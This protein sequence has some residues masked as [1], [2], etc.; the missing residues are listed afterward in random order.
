MRERLRA[1]ARRPRDAAWLDGTGRDHGRGRGGG[2]RGATRA[3]ERLNAELAAR[4]AAGAFPCAHLALEDELP[5]GDAVDAAKLRTAF[6]AS[7]ARDAESGR[8]AVGPHLADLLVRHTVKRA[9]ARDCSTGEQ[10]ALLDLHRAGQCLAAARKERRRRAASAAG[11]NRR[12]SR[13]RAPRRAVRRSPGAGHAGLDDRHG[14]R[15]VRAARGRMLNSSPSLRARFVRRGGAM[16]WQAYLVLRGGVRLRVA[17]AGARGGRPRHALDRARVLGDRPYLVG[18][19]LADVI[20]LT[21]TAARP[22]GGRPGDGRGVL[23]GEDRGR[24]L[25]RVARLQTTGSR[26]STTPPSPPLHPQIEF[27]RRLC[28]RPRQSQGDRACGSALVPTVV[29]FGHVTIVRLSSRCCRGRCS[30]APR[31]TRAYMLA[32]VACAVFIT[33][34]QAR[35]RMNRWRARR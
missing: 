33:T 4:G 16:T 11:R 5:L 8:T 23:R 21:L 1:A 10:K 20:L 29:D 24:A 30:S 18:L 2:D 12:A 22:R 25:S 15:P 28:A 14:P 26:R 27:P 9:D 34:R 17:C 6:A 19:V 31:S 3:I 13:C 35:R 32:A 7:R